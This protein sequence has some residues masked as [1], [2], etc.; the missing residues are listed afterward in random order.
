MN[1]FLIDTNILTF[2]LR[3][4]LDRNTENLLQDYSNQIYISSI[5]VMEFINLVQ[6][7]RVKSKKIDKENLTK[8]IEEKLGFTIL[9]VTK[10]HLEELEKLPLVPKHNDPNDRLIIAQAIS[11]RLELVSTDTK[12]VHYCQYGLS[13]IKARH[14]I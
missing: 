4:L 1:R 7:E 5:S 3:E 6:S 12:F 2:F 14:T 10:Y 9:Y 13:L 8:M 11:N